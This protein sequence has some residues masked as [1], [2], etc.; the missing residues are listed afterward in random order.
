MLSSTTLLACS[1]CS[2]SEVP[3]WVH[4]AWSPAAPVPVTSMMSLVAAVLPSPVKPE[5]AAVKLLVKA[6]PEPSPVRSSVPPL[7]PE[8]AENRSAR[9][10]S[11][12]RIQ[13]QRAAVDDRGIGD[14]AGQNLFQAAAIDGRAGRRASSTDI[15]R[16]AAEHRAVAV[17]VAR[18][19][20]PPPTYWRAAAQNR[21]ARRLPIEGPIGIADI[22]LAAAADRCVRRRS[23]PVVHADALNAAAVDRGAR[24]RPDPA[25]E[26][27]RLKAA[28]VDRRARRRPVPPKPTSCSPPPRSLLVAVPLPLVT[29][30]SC[31]AAQDR[32]R[33]SPG[34]QILDSRPPGSR[35]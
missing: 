16:A 6:E 11:G 8:T 17:P 33:R 24:R 35:R 25:A 3:L 34:P 19:S 27:D 13:P 2:V 9:C 26:A 23:G 10:R 22:L 32:V 29:P 14:A 30:I 31:A 28:I 18:A 7:V 15:L 5:I 1:T 12:A 21:R 4:T 20:P